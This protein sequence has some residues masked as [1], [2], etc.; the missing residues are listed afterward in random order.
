[1]LEDFPKHNRTKD[2]RQSQCLRCKATYN[3]K[4]RNTS[5]G[6]TARERSK[7][8][9]Y[10]FLF[11]RQRGRCAICGIH[12]FK[13]YRRLCVDHDHKTGKIRGLL[14]D[15]CNIKLAGFDNKIFKKKAEMYL[16]AT[17]NF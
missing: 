11:K 17:V 8:K 14:C 1:M 5:S 2:G 9:K 16:K 13:L 4:Y 12:Q 3:Q 7:H 6:K 10:N 15:G